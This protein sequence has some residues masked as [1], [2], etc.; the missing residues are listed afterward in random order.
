MPFI[1]DT[2]IDKALRPPLL[3]TLGLSFSP[4]KSHTYTMGNRGEAKQSE[5]A[6]RG[7]VP[8]GVFLPD[9]LSGSILPV[10]R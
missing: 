2:L 8:G 7:A 3:H 6:V 4:E 1:S 9:H 10:L 5:L